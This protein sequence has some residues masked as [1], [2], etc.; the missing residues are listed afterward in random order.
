[1]ERKVKPKDQ[2]L[3][4]CLG[5]KVK[6]RSHKG[7]KKGKVSKELGKEK[8]DGNH[9]NSIKIKETTKLTEQIR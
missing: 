4:A 1:M 8:K 2:E 5:Y 3:K 7:G 6:Q 9:K